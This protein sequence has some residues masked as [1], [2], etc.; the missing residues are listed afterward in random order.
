M[1]VAAGLLWANM[2]L[3]IRE[4]GWTLERSYGWPASFYRQYTSDVMRAHEQYQLELD[5]DPGCVVLRN[6]DGTRRTIVYQGYYLPLSVALDAVI[7]V[8]ILL[9]VAIALEWRIRRRERR[10]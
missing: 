8:G 6:A 5:E 4:M 9:S 1:F 2:T 7:A 3:R 10:Q